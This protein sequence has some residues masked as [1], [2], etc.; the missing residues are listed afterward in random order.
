MDDAPYAVIG[1]TEGLHAARAEARRIMTESNG[2]LVAEHEQILDRLLEADLVTG[3]EKSILLSLFKIGREAGEGK[4]DPARA[5]F[6]SRA[7][8][9]KLAVSGRTSPVALIIAS[10]NVGAFDVNPGPDGSPTVVVYRLS[11]GS[12]L[13]GIGAGIGAILGGVAGG[14][15]GGQIGGFIGGVIDEKKDKKK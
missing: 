14:V 4:I 2:D 6:E 3:E 11:Y 7:V 10:A 9:D 12:S 1:M 5:Y 8:Y 15:L 13:A